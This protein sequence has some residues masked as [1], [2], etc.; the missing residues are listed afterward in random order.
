MLGMAGSEN[1]QGE[2]QKK[3]DIVANEVFKNV[4]RRSGQCAVLVSGS[5]AIGVPSSPC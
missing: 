2:D 1:V 4:L 3:L 5:P